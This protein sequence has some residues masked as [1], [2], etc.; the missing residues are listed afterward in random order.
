VEENGLAMQRSTAMVVVCCQDVLRVVCPVGLDCTICIALESFGA[1]R[2]GGEH[3][4]GMPQ[5]RVLIVFFR[6]LVCKVVASSLVAKVRQCCCK[7]ESCSRLKKIASQ[8]LPAVPT[9]F[10]G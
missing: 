5:V 3:L 10:S 1:D 8:L 2:P 6:R 7:V 4:G 9:S